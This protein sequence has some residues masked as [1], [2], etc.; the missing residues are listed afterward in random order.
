[1]TRQSDRDRALAVVRD[2]R[3]LLRRFAFDVRH[4]DDAEFVDDAECALA[5]L[6]RALGPLADLVDD[7]R[8][9]RR[10]PRSARPPG[11]GACIDGDAG[12]PRLY[13]ERSRS[14]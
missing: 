9:R 13:I 11:S 2:M 14:V 8:G 12:G 5:D 1:M 4:G 7:I 6:T 3:R 10:R